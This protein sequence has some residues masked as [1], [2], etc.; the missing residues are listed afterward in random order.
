MEDSTGY[1]RLETRED[2]IDAHKILSG[3]SEFESLASVAINGA[4]A[5]EKY[6]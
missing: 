1:A 3:M 4:G 5:Y 2:A 6:G